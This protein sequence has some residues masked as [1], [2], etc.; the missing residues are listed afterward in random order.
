MTLQQVLSQAEQEGAFPRAVLLAGTKGRDAATECGDGARLF[1]LASLTKVLATT[2]AAMILYERG[3]FDLDAPVVSVVPEFAAGDDRKKRVTMR[4]LLA[5]SSGLPAHEKFYLRCKSRDELLA[6][7]YA[8]P[9]EAEPMSRAVYSDIGFILLGEAIERIAEETLDKFCRRKIFEPLG[10]SSTMFNPPESLRSSIVPT[11]DDTWFRHRVI[12]G[13][14]HDD[15]AYVMGGVAGHAGLFSTADDVMKFA[16]C[17][18]RG[19]SPIF[20]PETVALFTTR[21]SS[22]VGT[23]RTL[24]WDT[25]SQPSQS[26]KYLS[27]RAY[28]H[29]GYTG[30]SL[31]IDPEKDL[32]IVLLTNRTWPD[33]KNEAIKQWRPRIHDAVV[34]ELGLVPDSQR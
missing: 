4:M 29:L 23:T 32:A 1:D 15:N 11:A 8:T 9:L 3:K 2:A 20:K 21:E 31:W 22:P 33:N 18:L 5:H 19:G 13:E 26:G 17:M 10:M 12:Q 6:A 24:G 28:G 27:S 25:P 7:V 14:V 16:Q 30:T 34:E